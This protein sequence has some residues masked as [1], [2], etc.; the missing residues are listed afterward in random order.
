MINVGVLRG[1]TVTKRVHTWGRL[2]DSCQMFGGDGRRAGRLVCPGDLCVSANRRPL[3]YNFSPGFGRR[4]SGDSLGCLLG[5]CVLPRSASVGRWTANRI[6][7]RGERKQAS[8]KNCKDCAISISEASTMLVSPTGRMGR[9]DQLKS[10]LRRALNRR[11]YRSEEELCLS[12]HGSSIGHLIFVTHDPL[13]R[14]M[15][16]LQIIWWYPGSTTQKIGRRRD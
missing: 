3:Q 16:T 11:E 12:L 7:H 10:C 14:R 5:R 13:A 6:T 8:G 1:R 9:H 15:H 2:R 4:A